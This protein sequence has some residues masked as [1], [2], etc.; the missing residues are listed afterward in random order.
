MLGDLP[1]VGIVGAGLIG[2]KRAR[3]LN[4][5]A[6]LISF[7]EPNSIV[8]DEFEKQFNVSPSFNFSD[9]LEKV[10]NNGVV[11]ICVPTR[12]AFDLALE[13]IKAGCHVLIEKPGALNKVE[14]SQLVSTANKYK[15][16][17]RIG[18]NHRFHPGINNLIQDATSGIYGSIQLIR[19]RYGHGGRLG[20]E[21]EW[22]AKRELAGGGELMDQGSHL[23]DLV[24]ALV[25]EFKVNF[26]SLPTLFWDMEVEDNAFISGTSSNG[27]S[28][29]LQSSWTEW[30][31]IFDLEVFCKTA[32]L[33]VTGLGGSYGPEVYAK[34]EMGP[35]MGPPL[36]TSFQYPP[37]DNSW[38]LE[39]NDL[40]QQISE[41]EHKISG[42]TGEDGLFVIEMIEELYRDY[43]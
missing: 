42:A 26:G 40:F 39:L 6:E 18:Y 27:A 32:K 31:N 3:A 35:G 38:F 16:V 11:L 14:I 37:A 7:V 41:S 34:F 22:R 8:A 19:A 30:K 43:L 2:V 5:I 28:I 20:Y 25:G 33:Q 21:N 29:W 13:S 9:L 24:H 10:G 23:I 1:K 17:L 12:A 15:T 4:G 36:K